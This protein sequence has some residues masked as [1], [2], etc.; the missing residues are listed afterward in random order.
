MGK[1]DKE[2]YQTAAGL[3]MPLIVF[4]VFLIL[5]LTHLIGW[6]W[7]W[8]TSPLW[9]VAALIILTALISSAVIYIR[10]KMYKRKL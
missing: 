5:R 10:Y 8:V 2:D 1:A 3:S 4:L 6:S 9:I 7:W